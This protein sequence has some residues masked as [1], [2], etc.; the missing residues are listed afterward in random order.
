MFS[1]FFNRT[2]YLNAFIIVF[3]YSVQVHKAFSQTTEK[4]VIVKY[5][6]D[7][8]I[9]DAQLNEP[10]WD[11][12]KAAT[13][14]WQY[15][16]SDSTQAK[17]Q[18]SIKFLFDDKNLY[19]G[20]KVN[21]P[22]NKFIT[23]SLRRDF[24]AGGSDNITFLFDTFNDG[25]NAFI[26]G[27]N[28]YGVKREMLLSGGGTELRGFTMAWD[29]KWKCKTAIKDD[30]YIVEMIIPLSA[31][32]YKEG[33]TK[34]RFNSY[35]FD[36]QENE[37]NTWV[38]IPQNQFIFNLAYMGD[39]IFEK[40]LG[41]SKSPVS[42]IP[43]VNT[44]TSNDFENNVAF[45]DFKFGGD[46]KFTI[47]NSLNLDVTINPDFSQVEVDQQVTNLTRFEVSLPERRQFFIEN[48]D[49]FAD[50]GNNRDSNP[51]FSRR[52]GIGEDLEGNSIENN[53]IA[54]I[55]LSGKLTNNLRVGL[56]NMQT[57]EDVSNEIP[58]VNNSVVTIQQ[59]MFSR[60]NLSF[61]FINK[62][63]T[64]DYDFLADKDRYNRVVGIDYRLASE[65]NSWVGKY[66]I[67]KSFSP[68]VSKKDYSAGVSTQYF[69]RNLNIRLSGVYVGD[70]YN[71][72]LGFIRRTDIIK[73]N[74]RIE[75]TYWLRNRKIQ[76]HSFSFTPIAIW[77]PELN[78][79]NSDYT[80]ISRWNARFN[81]TSE[82]QF[83]M[84]NRFTRLYDAFDPS[85]SDNA[86]PLP[87]GGYH[88]TSF[89]ASFRSDQRKTISYRIEPS[90]GAFYNG[91]KYSFEGTLNWR[92]QPYLSGSLQL[93][94]D[95]IN[96]PNP[97]PSASIWL[98]GPRIDVTFNK[99]LF[100]ATFVQYSNQQDNFGIN[101]RLQ[102]RFA[103]LSDLFIVYNDNYFSTDFGPKFRSLNLKLTYWLNI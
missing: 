11:A 75:R 102:W 66:F 99:S 55:R 48:N 98:V 65:D 85:S 16:P 58:T 45:N 38:N 86:T 27:T 50:F 9:L 29:T 53:I 46:V 39:M 4:S 10:S 31:F 88:Y 61:M 103:P 101:T 34:W 15:F 24:S 32:K 76:T 44:I 54:G 8:I 23:P 12:A 36:T 96:L 40:P 94:F 42:L 89:Q 63:T 95:Q 7:P 5:I 22:D 18:A 78:F 57:E 82:L 60:S 68:N 92:V 69:S 2:F 73:I 51:F 33:E 62:Q 71:S 41:S 72:E 1:N 21:A 79:Q 91:H 93:N 3:L 52:I 97:Y 19:I 49:L 77:K 20:A 84:F 56:L 47:G 70:N 81:N 100:W 28:P 35:H 25:T 59:K 67:H 43:Y 30:H 37:R 80:I 87:I 83:G 26:F 6:K 17:Q 64:K 13:N 90:I 14:Y 74:P